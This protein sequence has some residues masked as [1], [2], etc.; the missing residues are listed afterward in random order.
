MLKQDSLTERKYFYFWK[1]CPL[2]QWHRVIPV[3]FTG[4]GGVG[5]NS[6]EQY[7]MAQKALLFNDPIAHDNI[8]HDTHPA[9]M[10]AHGRQ[11]FGYDQ[12]VWE[13]HRFGIVVTGNIL[14]F[15]QNPEAAK[16]LTDL[17]RSGYEFVEASPHDK[18]WGIGISKAAAEDG[19][20]WKGM[21]LLGMALTVVADYLLVSGIKHNGKVS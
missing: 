9:M 6:T 7:M 5:Y 8:M 14:K 20:L 19:V 3:Q 18:I 12:S 21:N 16:I 4:P 13:A 10:K 2:T 17:R 15:S 11:V 1:M